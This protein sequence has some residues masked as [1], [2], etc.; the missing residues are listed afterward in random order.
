MKK[1]N[2]NKGAVYNNTRSLRIYLNDIKKNDFLSKE[3]EV[4]LSQNALQGDIF[5][6]NTLIKSNLRFGVQV[7]RKYIG[8]GLDIEDLISHANIGL[9]EAANKFEASRGV[10]FLSFAVWHIRA[11]INNAL[12]D[13]SRT[14]RLP[15]HKVKTEEYKSYSI[16]SA[17]D[18]EMETDNFIDKFFISEK[19]KCYFEIKDLKKDI[20]RALSILKPNERKAIKMFYSIGYDFNYSMKKIALK[21][22]ISEERVRQIIREGEKKL[23]QTKLYT[24]L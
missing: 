18:S 12:N 2:V 9:Y 13:L 15:S 6:I 3:D 8:M 21:L 14:V 7:A 4:V 11:E 24:Y 20:E 1:I 22:N 10:R 16:E 5:A 17:T 23:K 19:P